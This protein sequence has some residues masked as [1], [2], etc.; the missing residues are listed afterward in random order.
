MTDDCRCR[1]PSIVGSANGTDAFA[2]DTSADGGPSS[3][4]A[5]PSDCTDPAA[6]VADSWAPSADS[7]GH[8]SSCACLAVNRRWSVGVGIASC[9]RCW[10][11]CRAS[12]WR[13]A[14][15]NIKSIYVIIFIKKKINPLPFA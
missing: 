2:G 14:R 9:R 7:C 8:R 4:D 11:C 12:S 15:N 1:V 3:C 13:S 10:S 6:A 5:S